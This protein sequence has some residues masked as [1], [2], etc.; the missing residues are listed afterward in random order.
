MHTNTHSQIS[1]EMLGV[2]SIPNV[3]ALFETLFPPLHAS[4]FH[5]YPGSVP[6]D[7]DWVYPKGVLLTICCIL[8]LV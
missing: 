6:V 2:S 1:S 4:A 8:S 7:P 3:S 5:T